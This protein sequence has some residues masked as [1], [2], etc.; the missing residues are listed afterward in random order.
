MI[1]PRGERPAIEDARQF[2]ARL[3]VEDSCELRSAGLEELAPL[4]ALFARARTRQEAEKNRG[5][6]DLIITC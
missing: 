4:L 3:K 1:T 2:T 5:A 6:G